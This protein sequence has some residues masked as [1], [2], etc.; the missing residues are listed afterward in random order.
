MLQKEATDRGNIIE[1][2]EML[3]NDTYHSC[4]DISE[5]RNKMYNSMKDFTQVRFLSGRRFGEVFSVVDKYNE[6][7]LLVFLKFL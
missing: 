4:K 7:Y 1:I 6:K 5:I 2:L 3:I